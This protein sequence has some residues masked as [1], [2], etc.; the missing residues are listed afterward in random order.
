MSKRS[1]SSPLYSL[2]ISVFL[3]T[4]E[5]PATE[6]CVRASA[7]HQFSVARNCAAGGSQVLRVAIDGHPWVVFD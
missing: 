7:L 3:P 5:K 6:M 2:R 4:D 1:W